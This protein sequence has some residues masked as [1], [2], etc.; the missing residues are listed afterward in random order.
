MGAGP[1]RSAGPAGSTDQPT[2]QRLVFHDHLA[3][4]DRD[5]QSLAYRLAQHY[6]LKDFGPLPGTE[7]N[8]LHRTS[9][10]QAGELLLSGGYASPLLGTI[11]DREGIGSINLIF[12]GEVCYGNDGREVVVNQQRPFFFSP[13]HEYTYKIDDHFNGVVF[14]IDLQRLQRTAA[15]IAGLGISE[16]RFSSALDHV[17]TVSTSASRNA[18]LLKV[19]SHTFSLLDNPELEMLGHLQHLQ[20]DDLIYRNLA[21]ILCPQLENLSQNDSALRG[22]RERIFED[23]LE[24][25]RANL[26][27]PINLT[28]LEQRSGYSRRSLQLVFQ[29]RFGCGPIQWIRRQRLEQARRALLYPEPDDTV[30][31]IAARFG[32]SSLSV[33]SRDFSSHF[34]LRPSDLLREG[35]APRPS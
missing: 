23:L 4:A 30:G 32:F 8:F 7:K 27:Q 21:L 35:R 18:Q 12:T 26:D 10:C 20:L 25:A 1:A 3:H 6:S 34:G 2:C 11:G 29:Q 24:W 33:F 13:G 19:L 22:Q 31:T 28:Q 15:S 5:P 14:H 17:R 9:T 16:R